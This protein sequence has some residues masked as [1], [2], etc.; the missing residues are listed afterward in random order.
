MSKT[1]VLQAMGSC[2]LNQ[3]QRWAGHVCQMDDNHSLTEP[4]LYSELPNAP[5]PTWYP[6]LC[7]W[8]VL[9]HDLNTFSI[10]DTSSEKLAR[11][12]M[13]EVSH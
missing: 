6:K 7:F 10:A 2:D 11:K 9:K 1:L 8:D 4:V 13:V 12:R 3:H 5:Q